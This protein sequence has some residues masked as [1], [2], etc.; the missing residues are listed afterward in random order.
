MK[1]NSNPKEVAAP[2]LTTISVSQ[3]EKARKWDHLI[4]LLQRPEIRD[5]YIWQLASL[6]RAVNM[7]LARREELP[8]SL[9]EELMPYK[10]KLEALRLEA[11]DGFDGTQGVLNFLP[12]YVTESLVGQLC[13]GD[14]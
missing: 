6:H 13:Q 9:V 1:A 8:P 4:R 5:T 11:I 3:Q 2:S 14:H 10:E 7:L 12:T